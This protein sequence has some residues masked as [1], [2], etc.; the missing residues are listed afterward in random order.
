MAGITRIRTRRKR[1]S[2][3]QQA[4]NVGRITDGLPEDGESIRLFNFSEFS[5]CG[6]L[7][8]IVDETDVDWL[9]VVTF[10]VGKTVTKLLGEY[11]AAGR[12]KNADFILGELSDKGRGRERA[13][14]DELNALAV[15]YGWTV[16]ASKNHAKVILFDTPRGKYVIETSANLNELASWEF[17]NI[18]KSEELFRFYREMIF[19]NPALQSRPWGGSYRAGVVAFG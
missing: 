12:I 13:C 8:W 1:L 3:S 18:E 10:R 5:A 6:M 16:R 7:R 14:A 15:R 2:A 9:G 4:F 11:A 19:D 17:F